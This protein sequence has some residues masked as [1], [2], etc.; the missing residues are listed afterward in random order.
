MKIVL[1]R[2][3]SP[4]AATGLPR[5]LERLSLENG[6]ALHAPGGFSDLPRTGTI[7]EYVDCQNPLSSLCLESLA[8][9]NL[10]SSSL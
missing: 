7:R 2:E 8:T 4:T 1:F 10:A 6:F 9:R 3:R 5:N